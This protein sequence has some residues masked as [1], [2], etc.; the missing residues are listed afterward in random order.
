LFPFIIS[1]IT[2]GFDGN[3][4][5]DWIGFGPKLIRGAVLFIPWIEID[6]HPAKEPYDIQDF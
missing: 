2:N 3:Y 1:I 6:W 5:D 4:W